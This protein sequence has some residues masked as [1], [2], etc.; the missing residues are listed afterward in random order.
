MEVNQ[1][2]DY[3]SHF[4]V[5]TALNHWGDSQKSTYLAASL[6]GPAQ[7]LLNRVDIYSPSGYQ[8]LL[9]V[10]QERYARRVAP[11]NTEDSKTAKRRNLEVIGDKRGSFPAHQRGI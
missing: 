7:R 6:S 3:L 1:L 11:G 10:L 4:E 9:A 2:A 8:E 5:V